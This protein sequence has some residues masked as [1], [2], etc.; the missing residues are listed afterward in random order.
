M[1]ELVHPIFALLAN[2]FVILWQSDSLVEEKL[3][4]Y[5]AEICKL[6]PRDINIVVLYAVTIWVSI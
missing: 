6:L 5:L 3:V 1:K 2:L 4:N